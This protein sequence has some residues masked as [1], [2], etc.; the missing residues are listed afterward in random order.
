MGERLL[1]HNEPIAAAFIASNYVSRR[2]VEVCGIMRMDD[3]VK[4]AQ[5][6]DASI[7]LRR[8]R[9]LVTYFSF[10][11]GLGLDDRGVDPFPKN[12]RLGWYDLFCESHLEFAK[13]ALRR[14]D[15][16]FVIKTKWS[17]QWTSL[18]NDTLRREGIEPD[19]VSNLT[20]QST[21]NAHNL[22]F[23]SLVVC[24]FSSTTVLEAALAGKPVVIPHFGEV[25]KEGYLGRVKLLAN[26]NLF[27]VA[28]SPN[29]FGQLIEERLYKPDIISK[30]H[31]E[32]RQLFERWVSPL[33]GS[34]LFRY[35]A[36]LNDTA[37]RG[38]SSR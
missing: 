26:Y 24:S 16:D 20:I 28:Y 2:Q 33:D 7:A 36:A 12:P 6:S 27:D 25:G 30:Q 23:E 38:V 19:S 31:D 35:V 11:L 32:R 37:R 34:A 17:G 4:R 21:G 1:V 29:E 9:P 3:F 14:P 18:I 8:E 5:S 10:A 15:I 22:I 13:L